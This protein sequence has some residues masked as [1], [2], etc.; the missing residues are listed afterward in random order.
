DKAQRGIARWDIAERGEEV[1]VSPVL[2]ARIRDEYL[3]CLFGL[4]SF[5]IDLDIVA[6][7]DLNRAVNIARDM[8]APFTLMND[9]G[10]VQAHALVAKFCAAHPDFRMPQSLERARATGGWKL[11]DVKRSRVG[12]VAVLKIR[13]PRVL[14]ALNGGVVDSLKAYLREAEADSAVTSVVITGHGVKAFVSGADIDALAACGTAEQ[15]YQFSRNFQQLTEQIEAMRKPVVC[16]LN[17]LAFGGG[18]ELALGCAARV[19][20]AG[21]STLAALPEP[22]LGI[23]PGGGGTQRLPRLIGV[24]AAARLIRTGAAV[25]SDAALKLGL[26]D[27]L[28]DDPLE[29]AIALARQLAAGSK[30]AKALPKGKI[31]CPAQLPEV[32]IGY[33]SRCIDALLCQAIVEGAQGTLAQGLELEARL[34][35][36]CMETEDAKIGIDNFKRAGARSKAVFV[37]R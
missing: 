30:K 20:R 29:A 2:E 14:N 27:E 35:G 8:K 33:F 16:A 9:M 13:R 31:D 17:G 34:V 37:H 26:V 15:A 22:T 11:S 18:V 4:V 24:E 10:I 5:I 7:D 12:D 36:R 25:S 1:A 28:A 21:L 6:I 3:G 32:D 23:I 19:A